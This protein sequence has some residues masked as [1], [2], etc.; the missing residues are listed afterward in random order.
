MFRDPL[1]TAREWRELAAARKLSIRE[2]VIETTGRQT[3]IGSP[4][5]VAAAIDDLV[6]QDAADGFILVPHLTPGGLDGFADTVVP[7]LQERGVFR[8]EYSGPTLRDHLGL[9]APR[10]PAPTG[11]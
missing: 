8:R 1:A 10:I 6:Q 7:L 5:T 3:F 11:P 2:L 9:A 4:A